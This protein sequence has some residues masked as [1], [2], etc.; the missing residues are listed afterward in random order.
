[1]IYAKMDTRLDKIFVLNSNLKLTSKKLA[2]LLLSM[3]EFNSVGLVYYTESEHLMPIIAWMTKFVPDHLIEE[4]RVQCEHSLFARIL[5]SVH[6]IPTE[7]YPGL[8]HTFG[9]LFIKLIP[10]PMLLGILEQT[11][12][13]PDSQFQS[14]YIEY[15]DMLFNN[16]REVEATFF[17]HYHHNE[18]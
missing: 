15:F 10:K 16:V 14:Y 12:E 4:P 5:K 1:V 6:K 2:D 9:I 18:Y 8:V 7:N 3:G 11:K 17:V 13:S